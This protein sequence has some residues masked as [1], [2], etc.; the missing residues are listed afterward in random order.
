[1]ISIAVGA[2]LFQFRQ[3]DRVLD[4]R[5][6]FHQ[7]KKISFNGIEKGFERLAACL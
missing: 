5:G 7:S 4:A 6:R 1:M 2:G 3:Y